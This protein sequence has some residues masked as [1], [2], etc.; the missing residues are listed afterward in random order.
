MSWN[1]PKFWYV[2]ELGQLSL[3]V[4]FQLL[5]GVTLRP[6][7]PLAG[8]KKAVFYAFSKIHISAS[9]QPILIQRPAFSWFFLKVSIKNNRTTLASKPYFSQLLK[10]NTVR[11]K[12]GGTQKYAKNW[13]LQLNTFC[14]GSLEGFSK[15]F[16]MLVAE[17][18]LVLYFWRY[19]HFKIAIYAK[20]AFFRIFKPM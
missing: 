9:K 4:N 14:D 15:T 5:V 17:L 18:Y 13:N 20:V 12:A 7:F 11:S 3:R 16:K 19:R 2:V 6:E 1:R 8:T 10:R